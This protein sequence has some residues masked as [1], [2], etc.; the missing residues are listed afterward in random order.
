MLQV[1]RMKIRLSVETAQADSRGGT[2][3]RQTPHVKCEMDGYSEL[4][5]KTVRPY[6][7]T[8]MCLD[9]VDFVASSAPTAAKACT[10]V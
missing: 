5:R 1:A 8:M 6:C 9:V 2:N 10:G 4:S 3:N 7:P